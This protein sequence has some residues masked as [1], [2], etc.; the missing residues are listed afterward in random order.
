MN[1]VITYVNT[2]I[3]PSPCQ[4]RCIYCKVDKTWKETAA[5]REG[6]DKIFEFLDHAAKSGAIHP[7]AFWQ[8]AFGEITIHPYKDRIIKVAAGK[9]AMYCTNGFIYDEGIA[10][11]LK[12]NPASHIQ[13]SIDAGTAATWQK[14]K[15]FDNFPEVLKNLARYEKATGG[16]P[17]AIWMKYLILPGINDTPEEFFAVT[18]IM[19]KLGT[20]HMQLS[21]DFYGRH[22]LSDME[23]SKLV[24]SA[25][26][27]VSMCRGRGLTADSGLFGAERSKAIDELSGWM[28]KRG[29]FAGEKKAALLPEDGLTLPELT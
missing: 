13:I 22:D 1:P 17:G 26:W 28:M 25:A 7:Q 20:T 2:G 19:K 15:G 27:L 9:P 10:E 16:R 8:I 6:Y 11:E 5:V 18:E 3:Y 12:K 23:L 21:H 4:C 29:L 24:I 14:V